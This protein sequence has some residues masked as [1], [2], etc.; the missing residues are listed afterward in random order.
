MSKSQSPSRIFFFLSTLLAILGASHAQLLPWKT[1]GPWGGTVKFLRYSPKGDT[2]FALSN[3]GLHQ[4]VGKDGK[5]ETLPT[6]GV[7]TGPVEFAI[8]GDTIVMLGSGLSVSKD[9]GLTWKNNSTLGR[10]D[11][12]AYRGGTLYLSR[13]TLV[14]RSENLG[15]SIVQAACAGLIINTASRKAV[16]GTLEL[17]GDTLLVSGGDVFM[18]TDKAE[19]FTTLGTPEKPTAIV[20][21]SAHK[22]VIHTIGN[23]GKYYYKTLGTP[24]WNLVKTFPNVAYNGFKSM[25][26]GGRN[27]MITGIGT[28]DFTAFPE[29]ALNMKGIAGLSVGGMLVLD[30]SNILVSAS[31]V[32]ASI[33]RT[34]NGGTDWQKIDINGTALASFVKT[35]TALYAGG[36]TD[37]FKSGLDGQT[38]KKIDSSLFGTYALAAHASGLYRFANGMYRSTDGGATW[39][40]WDIGFP[41]TSFRTFVSGA[42]GL[43]A[44]S[45]SGVHRLADDGA[46][47]SYARPWANND[48]AQSGYISGDTLQV[49]MKAKD[50]VRFHQTTDKGVTWTQFGAVKSGSNTFIS[51][52]AFFGTTA[53]IGQDTAFGIIR[54]GAVS[55]VNGGP[56]RLQLQAANGK[57]FIRGTTAIYTFEIS[58]IPTP[59]R[60][61][62]LSQA[63]RAQ[64]IRFLGGDR[65]AVEFTLALRQAVCLEIYSLSGKLLIRR[66]LGVWDAGTHRTEISRMGSGSRSI[67]AIL[68]S[69]NRALAP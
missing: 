53:L 9:R 17:L 27:L 58:A 38:W 57:F 2:L 41:L 29:T 64:S 32:G 31:S 1:L 63:V 40:K 3:V 62:M 55:V 61:R 20:A 8:S 52:N 36:G 37:V 45:D 19:A 24:T 21:M 13:D 67:L 51:L 49:I 39:V 43:F 56:V 50:S 11:H 47:W 18:S 16:I 7:T 42:P 15:D 28:Y 25:A 69:G 33:Y 14:F 54:D 34:A 10:F 22:G 60:E 65:M 23:F 12:L 35:D 26:I 5:W 44:L 46:S 48:F 6:Q 59:V 68:K 4:S 30:S 66:N